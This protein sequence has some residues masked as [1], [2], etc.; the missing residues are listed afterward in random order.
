MCVLSSKL[1]QGNATSKY[2]QNF[3]SERKTKYLRQFIVPVPFVDKQAAKDYLYQKNWKYGQV[4]QLIWSFRVALQTK[5]KSEFRP[6][7]TFPSK[8]K[9][10][11]FLQVCSR[12]EGH[13]GDT[14]EKPPWGYSPTSPCWILYALCFSFL[15][16]RLP[17]R[18]RVHS[19]HS[20]RRLG[21]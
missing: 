18:A 5:T 11:L 16:C 20:A 10:V 1:F 14:E 17:E 21:E 12:F 3:N 8:G 13:C 9:L 2:L 19:L 4:G 7:C 6:A 15:R